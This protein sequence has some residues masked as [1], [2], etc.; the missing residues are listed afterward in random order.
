MSIRE[1]YILVQIEAA[2]FLQPQMSYSASRI[3]KKSDNKEVVL[4]MLFPDGHQLNRSRTA[5]MACFESIY[6]LQNN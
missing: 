6:S 1:W 3:A 2:A 4:K 5:A